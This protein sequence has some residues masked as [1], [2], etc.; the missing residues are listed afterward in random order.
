VDDSDYQDGPIN[1]LHPIEHSE[2]ANPK[3]MQRAFDPTERLDRV[4]T[5]SAGRGSR[6]AELQ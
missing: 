4:P 6:H 2:V 5:D 1:L 3:A